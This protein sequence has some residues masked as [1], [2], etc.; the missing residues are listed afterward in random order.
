LAVGNLEWREP[1]LVLGARDCPSYFFQDS[2]EHTTC[3]IP[4]FTQLSMQAAAQVVNVVR[5]GF[6]Y[7]FRYGLPKEKIHVGNRLII[8]STHKDSPVSPDILRYVG[9]RCDLQAYTNEQIHKIL[10]QRTACLN[11]QV[12]ETSLRLIVENSQNNP[13]V[14]IRMLQMCYVISRSELRDSIDVTHCKKALA[15]QPKGI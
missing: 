3:Y 13:S 11:W 1:P 12:S 4:T 9:I 5:D 2:T 6:C 7:R 15:I 10:K 8:L 14:A